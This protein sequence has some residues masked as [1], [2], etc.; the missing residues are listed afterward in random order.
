MPSGSGELCSDLLKGDP[1]EI[2]ITDYEFEETGNE[3]F[4]IVLVANSGHGAVEVALELLR[5]ELP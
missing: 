4:E 3:M 2:R 1:K 5:G